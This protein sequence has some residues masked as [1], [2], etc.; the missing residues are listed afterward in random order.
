MRSI[1]N[2]VS[3]V[4]L[5]TSMVIYGHA[6]AQ[7]ISAAKANK[8]TLNNADRSRLQDA[9]RI[10]RTSGAKAAAFQELY[11][12]EVSNKHLNDE[13]FPYQSLL[14]KAYVLMLAE[15]KI[16]TRQEAKTILK[17]LETADQQA[18]TNPSLH[19]YLPYEMAVIKAVGSVGGKMKASP[20]AWTAT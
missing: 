9:S 2:Y 15:Q 11:D 16:I 12:Y 14:H 17:G 18:A 3:L 7:M 5:A 6:D 20:N 8:D 19:L 13:V 1:G 4:V 10:G